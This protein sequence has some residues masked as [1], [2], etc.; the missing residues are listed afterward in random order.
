V[1]DLSLDVRFDSSLY[2]KVK[3]ILQILTPSKT[4]SGP[5]G[6]TARAYARL[7]QTYKL[8]IASGAGHPVRSILFT[9]EVRRTVD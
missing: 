8:Q 3:A 5:A 2:Y 1:H 7:C 6:T 4:R 9:T